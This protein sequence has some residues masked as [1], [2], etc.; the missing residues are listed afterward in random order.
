[1]ALTRDASLA[2]Y[3]RWG[4]VRGGRCVRSARSG[5]MDERLDTSVQPLQNPVRCS[6]YAPGRPCFILRFKTLAC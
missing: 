3:R 4:L 5:W 6:G 2:R 1:M